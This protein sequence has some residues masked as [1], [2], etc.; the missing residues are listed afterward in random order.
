MVHWKWQCWSFKIRIIY[1]SM[2]EL[3]FNRHSQRK[4]FFISFCV[5]HFQHLRNI[6]VD[7]I[8]KRKC[9]DGALETSANS[10]GMYKLY[11]TSATV[12]T[13]H[14][15][16]I[17]LLYISWCCCTRTPILSYFR[18]IRTLTVDGI[19]ITFTYSFSAR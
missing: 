1:S 15:I 14:F 19:F 2:T 5:C 18:C 17:W 4:A 12:T 6:C 13:I 10:I 8:L 3:T 16:L 11:C 9:L 7:V